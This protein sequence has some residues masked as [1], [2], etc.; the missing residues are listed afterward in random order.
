[1]SKC[2]VASICSNLSNGHHTIGWPPLSLDILMPPA[3]VWEFG[4]R[5]NTPGINALCLLMG[6][7]I[8]FSS[9]SHSQSARH[10]TWAPSTNVIGLPFTQITPTPSTCLHLYMLNPSTIQSSWPLL[11]FQDFQPPRNTLG[12][13]QK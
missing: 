12:A 6:P 3:P 7:K 8:L 13:V 5:A 2:R 9:M 11:I 4:S 1:M 10:S